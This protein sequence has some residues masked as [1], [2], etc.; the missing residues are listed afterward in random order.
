VCVCNILATDAHYNWTY[1][2][3]FVYIFVS[4]YMVGTTSSENF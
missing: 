4:K 2:C 3:L 1:Y